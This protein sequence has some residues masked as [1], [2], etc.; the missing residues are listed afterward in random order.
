MPEKHE[1]QERNLE[2]GPRINARKVPRLNSGPGSKY[3]LLVYWQCLRLQPG[4]SR[5]DSCAGLQS[6]VVVVWRNGSAPKTPFSF[7]VPLGEPAE[8]WL[9]SVKGVERVRFS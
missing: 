4:R 7:F 8:Q 3:V 5:F 2:S 6:K 9:S 1:S